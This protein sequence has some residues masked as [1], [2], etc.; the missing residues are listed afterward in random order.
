MSDVFKDAITRSRPRDGEGRAR[1][2]V[3]GP[4]PDC[5]KMFE[6]HLNVSKLDWDQ[7]TENSIDLLG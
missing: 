2:L 1:N 6:R 4:L 3:F 5:R 7:E